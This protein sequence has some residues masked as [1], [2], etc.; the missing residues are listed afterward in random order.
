MSL[1]KIQPKSVS[2]SDFLLSKKR[3]ARAHEAAHGIFLV[4]RK[5]QQVGI[6]YFINDDALI[7]FF[8]IYICCQNLCL[9]NL[10][11]IAVHQ[12]RI[13]NNKIGKFPLF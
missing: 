7:N 2:N 13:Y 11:F 10:I 12:V 8:T 1:E 5:I 6:G 9:Q 4:E 3:V